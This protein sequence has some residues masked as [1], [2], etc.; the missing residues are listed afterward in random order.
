MAETQTRNEIINLRATRRRKELIDRAAALLDRSRSDF[1][2]EAACR[3]AQALLVDQNHFS[4]PEEK[5]K[6]FLAALDRPPKD[7]PKLR[8]LLQSRAPWDR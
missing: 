3:E 2:L 7:N 4:L 5:F 8:Q 6:R 1:M